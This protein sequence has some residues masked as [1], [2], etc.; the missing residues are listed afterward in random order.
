MQDNPYNAPAAAVADFAPAG[1]QVLAGRGMRLVAV[2]I[3][4][5]IMLAIML[6]IMWFGGYFTGMLSG[7]EPSLGTQLLWSMGGFVAF[8]LVQGMP[9][10]ASGQTWGKKLMKM[11]IV[12]LQGNKPSIG[13]L[14]GMRYLPTQAIGL[15]PFV[16]ALYGLVNILF[17]FAEDRRCLHDKIAGT[18]VVVAE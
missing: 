17:I 12:D 4:A 14:I 2:L 11:K 5:V 3:D 9:L 6:P 1:E 13:N 16:G 18:R 7:V 15:V 10:A 8:V